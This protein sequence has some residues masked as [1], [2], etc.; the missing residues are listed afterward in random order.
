M[1]S[2]ST[3][4][5]DFVVSRLLVSYKS[6]K[7]PES[8]ELLQYLRFILVMHSFCW[9]RSPLLA[10]GEFVHKAIGVFNLLHY[11]TRLSVSKLVKCQVL[12]KSLFTNV[13]HNDTTASKGQS[14]WCTDQDRGVGVNLLCWQCWAGWAM[15]VFLWG[16]VSGVGMASPV[17][18]VPDANN[19]FWPGTNGL[20]APPILA[21]AML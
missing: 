7:Q 14:N 10:S 8:Q 5:V 21:L 3:Q 1:K 20:L 12:T 6:R 19:S 13:S 11:H 18:V 15:E 4:S 2:F 9:E 17:A 16:T